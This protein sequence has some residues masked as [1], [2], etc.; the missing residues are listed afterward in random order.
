MNLYERLQS[1]DNRIRKMYIKVARYLMQVYMYVWRR[2]YMNIL[3]QLSTIL[4]NLDIHAVYSHN[5]RSISNLINIIMAVLFHYSAKKIS[6]SL[7]WQYTNV[8]KL[9]YDRYSN[10][11]VYVIS[12]IDRNVFTL[13]TCY[14]INRT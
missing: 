6:K 7:K 11:F 14:S 3:S 1:N 4:T 8:Y 9:F 13:E 2:V 12:T 10:T 5:F